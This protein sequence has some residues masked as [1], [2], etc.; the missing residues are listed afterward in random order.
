MPMM[1]LDTLADS[2]VGHVFCI[3]R[4][5]GFCIADQERIYYISKI[6]KI[7]VI[8][9]NFLRDSGLFLRGFNDKSI[10]T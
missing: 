7:Y 6:L 2:H 4:Y 9:K 5:V 8:C 3:N 10:G 1:I